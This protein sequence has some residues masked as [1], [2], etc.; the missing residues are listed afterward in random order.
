MSG[1]AQTNMFVDD[2]IA[3]QIINTSNYNGDCGG[4]LHH[5]HQNMH[6]CKEIVATAVLYH[7]SPIQY[8]GLHIVH[9]INDPGENGNEGADHEY[10]LVKSFTTHFGNVWE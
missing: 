5:A 3:Q 1:R 10:E 6:Q 8:V 2:G 7:V 4:T 9:R